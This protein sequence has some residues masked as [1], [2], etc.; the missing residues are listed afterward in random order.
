MSVSTDGQIHFGIVFPE[1][2]EFPW[3]DDDQGEDDWWRSV[4]GFRPSFDPFTADGDYKPGVIIG[5]PRIDAYF[6][7]QKQWDKDNPLP[8]VLVSYQTVD[9]PAYM[10]A[11]PGI[12]LVARQ[13][14]PK[15][16][17]P[18]ALT[19]P[20]GAAARLLSFCAT[21]GIDNGQGMEFRWYLSSFWG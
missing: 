11:V 7:E 3:L 15:A 19:V 9:Y 18:T 17:D 21:Y 6:D 20:E 16:F 13:G 8:F 4:T 12:G 1:D 2:Y 14:H 10:L 5:D